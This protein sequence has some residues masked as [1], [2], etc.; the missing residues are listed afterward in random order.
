MPP[1]PSPPKTKCM[2]MQTVLVYVYCVLLSDFRKETKFQNITE[3]KFNAYGFV[4]YLSQF[5]ISKCKQIL[6]KRRKEE[7]EK[8]VPVEES[9]AVECRI[10]LLDEAR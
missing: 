10:I 1:P 6:N 3:V 2:G 9:L 8:S 4:V 5:K 7:E